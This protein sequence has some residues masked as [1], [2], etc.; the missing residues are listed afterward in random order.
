VW[1]VGAGPG[2]PE[3]LTLKALR[4]IQSADVVAYDEL[5]SDGVLELVPAQVQLLRVGRRVN[6]TRFYEG[7]VHPEVI[8]LAHAGRRVV[9]LKGGDPMIFGRA[10]EEIDGLR[11][12]GLEAEV[13]PGVSAGLAAAATQRI[14]LTYRNSARHVTIATAQTARGE[15]P[16]VSALPLG[17]TLVLY[18]GLGAV[19]E[20][21]QALMARGWHR[22]TPAA[23][24]SRATLPDERRVTAPLA[25]LAQAVFAAQLPTPAVIIVGEVVALGGSAV[26]DVVG[27]LQQITG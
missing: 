6:D 21:S 15:L 14:P 2:D 10:G 5:C 19:A 16:D 25:E 17:G 23:V 11:A 24:V 1:L 12:A 13:I 7:P 4:L 18:M 3:L 27:D 8:R 20:L 9:R 26:A 22:R